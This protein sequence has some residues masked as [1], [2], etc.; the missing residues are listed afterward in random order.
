MTFVVTEFYYVGGE[1][2]DSSISIIYNGKDKVKAFVSMLCKAKKEWRTMIDDDD[3]AIV[4]KKD[5]DKYIIKTPMFSG[6]RKK[7][8]HIFLI[9]DEDG[10]DD[11]IV[12]GYDSESRYD[13]SD[14]RG[15]KAIF[16]LHEN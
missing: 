4:D 3:D 5:I 11:C 14:T 13:F 2:D 1:P 15:D 10:D 12:V 8:P 9:G 7:K 6:L 16:E